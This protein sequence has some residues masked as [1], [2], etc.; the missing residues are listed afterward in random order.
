MASSALQQAQQEAEALRSWVDANRAHLLG[1][2]REAEGFVGNASALVQ[3]AGLLSEPPSVSPLGGATWQGQSP[4]LAALPG[5]PDEAPAGPF[6][7]AGFTGPVLE[8]DEQPDPRFL[9]GPPAREALPA[10]PAGPADNEVDLAQGAAGPGEAAAAAAGV[11]TPAD[12]PAASPSGEDR[13]LAFDERAL[14]SFFSEQD[15]GDQR[16]TSRFRRRQ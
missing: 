13:S 4:D 5:V 1:V 2:L 9:E 10:P 15:L 6:A 7:E 12:G 11:D 8:D 3:N 14:D 16:S